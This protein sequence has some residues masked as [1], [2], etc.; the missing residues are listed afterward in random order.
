M[1]QLRVDSGTTISFTQAA[2]RPYPSHD[3]SLYTQVQTQT[4]WCW[5]ACLSMTFRTLAKGPPPAQATQCAVSTR[6]LTK[7]GDPRDCC[8]A[9]ATCNRPLSADDVTASW[10]RFPPYRSSRV[11][12][13]L[14]LDRIRDHLRD[15]KAPVQVGFELVN[16]V[17][18]HLLLIDAVDVVTG[19][20]K[21]VDPR[22]TA[23]AHGC[24]DDPGFLRPRGLGK[25]L[26]SWRIE[27][28][29]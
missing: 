11:G 9:P 4:E 29:V 17:R 10:G 7:P 3:L 23:K 8:L 13:C 1:S 14:P 27:G 21:L 24:L 26:Y 16:H 6:V 25:C 12:G 19:N 28:P 18:D 2:Q 22:T 15:A 20:V 5:A